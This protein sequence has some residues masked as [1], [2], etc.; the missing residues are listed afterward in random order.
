MNDMSKN[1]IDTALSAL[2]FLGK[3]WSPESQILV[4]T[5]NRHTKHNFFRCTSA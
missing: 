4:D 1:M 3:V 2:F 5:G